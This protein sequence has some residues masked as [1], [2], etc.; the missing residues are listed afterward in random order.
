MCDVEG[1][2]LYYEGTVVDI[3]RRKAAED[4]LRRVHEELELRVLERTHQLANANRA[5]QSEITVRKN[6]EETADRANRAKSVF[7]AT[8]SHE[9]RTPMN[10]ILGYAQLL[11]RSPEL[12]PAFRDPV[13]T[14]LEAGEHLLVVINDILDLSKIESGK[15]E[16][17]SAAVDLHALAQ[18]SVSMFEYK[19]RQKGIHLVLDSPCDGIL[20]RCDEGKLRQVLIN[21]LGNAVKFTDSGYVSLTIEQKAEDRFRFEVRDTGPGIAAEQQA[22][23]FDPFCQ[24]EAGLSRG[25]TGLGL[26]IA[27]DFVALMGGELDLASDVGEGASF[28]F[29]LPLSPVSQSSLEYRDNH[30]ERT[31]AMGTIDGGMIALNAQSQE[32]PPESNDFQPVRGDLGTASPAAETCSTTELKTLAAVL[33]T[34]NPTAQ[35][36][37]RRLRHLIRNFDYSGIKEMVDGFDVETLMEQT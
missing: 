5:L 37:V 12:T 25:G 24:A 29:T 3:T 36:F 26:A 19:A 30:L 4:S 23:I 9:I 18:S 31:A 8:M 6:A 11:E 35:Y 28:Y 14:I 21:L 15:I 34:E 22:T 32:R 20:V 27:R 10:A 17:V 16:L 13:E 7:L 2:V 33:E 1:R